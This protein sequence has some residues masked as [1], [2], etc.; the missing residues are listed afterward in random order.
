MK[1]NVD[2][3]MPTGFNYVPD[4]Y[5]I[6]RDCYWRNNSPV[7]E[8]T[9]PIFKRIEDYHIRLQLLF[10]KPMA[11]SIDLIGETFNPVM[12]MIR[13]TVIRDSIFSFIAFIENLNDEGLTL[14]WNEEFHSF[15]IGYN[16]LYNKPSHAE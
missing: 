5:V 4:N 16:H 11:F 14:S 12:H 3:G 1:M 6:G 13:G 10:Y 7:N 2:I 15:V 9:W 8:K